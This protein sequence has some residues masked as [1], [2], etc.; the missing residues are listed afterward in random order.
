MCKQCG[1]SGGVRQ[2]NEAD[3]P[4]Q[5]LTP[6]PFFNARPGLS[7]SKYSHFCYFIIITIIFIRRHCQSSS[8]QSIL[9]SSHSPCTCS[10]IDDVY[11]CLG[12]GEMFLCD[13]TPIDGVG[14]LVLVVVARNHLQPHNDSHAVRPSSVITGYC[15]VSQF[16][17]YWL[18]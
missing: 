17:R 15:G 12:V 6:A 5:K 10:T 18:S 1:G 11:G 7:H 13:L 14:P 2:T 9:S 8:T 16:R 3:G 4:R